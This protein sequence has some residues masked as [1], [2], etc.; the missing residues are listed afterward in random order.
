MAER[1]RA[2]ILLVERGLFESRARA[3]AAI[4]AGGVI[5]NGKLVLKP[6]E[7]LPADAE[8]LAEVY[9]AMT[10]GQESLIIDLGDDSASRI[11]AARPLPSSGRRKAQVV[12]RASDEEIAE[13]QQ[14]LAD[15]DE[16]SK[17]KCLWLHL[18]GGS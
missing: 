15:L 13:H 16:T 9:L 10:R 5:A 11:A 4:E 18:E 17:G 7:T 8:I 12:R 3:Q 14:A 6:S 2:D 1:K